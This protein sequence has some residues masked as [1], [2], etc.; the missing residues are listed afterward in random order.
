MILKMSCDELHIAFVAMSTI[1]E[2]MEIAGL[3]FLK[4]I[5]RQCEEIT[6]QTATSCTLLVSVFFGF[7]VSVLC[8]PS[9]TFGFFSR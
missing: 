9:V 6:P 8:L 4:N 7:N 1:T 5:Q 2:E 3:S